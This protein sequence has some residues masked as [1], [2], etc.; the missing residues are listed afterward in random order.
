MGPK[1]RWDW[2]SFTTFPGRQPVLGMW[3]SHQST[4]RIGFVSTILAAEMRK[5]S[6]DWSTN[7]CKSVPR[8][9]TAF[10]QTAKRTPT[11]IISSH[12]L[13][14]FP[15]MSATT[16]TSTTTATAAS[17][18]SN[19]RPWWRAGGILRPGQRFNIHFPSFFLAWYYNELPL[20]IAAWVGFFLLSKYICKMKTETCLYSFPSYLISM[21]V[22]AR[23]IRPNPVL[24]LL[25]CVVIGTFKVAICS[26][27]CLHRYCAH[28][29]YKT[30]STMLKIFICIVGCLA[31]QGGPI[32]W[33]S[34]HRCHHKHCEQ[35]EDPHS[36]TLVGFENAFAF[37]NSNPKLMLVNED[38]V[39]HY[40]DEPIYWVIDT[41]Y[42]AFC[43]LEMIVLWFF[44]GI[45]GFA[46]SYIS[47][48]MC[49]VR[50]FVSQRDH[51]AHH[52]LCCRCSWAGC[53]LMSFSTSPIKQGKTN[54]LV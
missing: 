11:F 26:S 35:P 47:G 40:I 42:W 2:L 22:A 15:T 7:R 43:T 51:N 12:G 16:I 49:Q 18:T 29:A 54:A 9:S 13:G 8:L 52:Y 5:V 41:F 1:G 53:T 30:D 14:S 48:F 25:M 21:V 28:T 19:P 46:A 4:W 10:T 33:S 31:N 23:H 39:P 27:A 45:P 34:H 32:W 44:Y 20:T 6:H 50:C 3:N 17:T 38:Y 24:F 37:F 36:P